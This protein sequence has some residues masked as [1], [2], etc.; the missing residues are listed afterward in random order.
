MRGRRTSNTES[1]DSGRAA[2]AAAGGGTFSLSETRAAGA[3]GWVVVDTRANTRRTRHE[4]AAKGL[5]G[6]TQWPPARRTLAVDGCRSAV[7]SVGVC[8]AVAV[9]ASSGLAAP[10]LITLGGMMVALVT[11]RKA[12]RPV[13]VGCG[14]G[15]MVRGGSSR[16]CRQRGRGCTESNARVHHLLVALVAVSVRAHV[17][18]AGVASRSVGW[19]SLDNE[20]NRAP[21]LQLILPLVC[22]VSAAFLPR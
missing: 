5:V 7:V 8:L 16:R 6:A 13:A 21:R 1:E 19:A 9:L 10:G 12:G 14:G 22:R 11:S 20:A 4:L 18:S 17:G 2:G 3:T 15:G